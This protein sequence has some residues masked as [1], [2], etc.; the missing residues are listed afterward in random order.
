MFVAFEIFYFLIFVL[1][2]FVLCVCVCVCVLC[3]FCFFN[4]CATFEYISACFSLRSTAMITN[5][6]CFVAKLQNGAHY[7]F[8]VNQQMKERTKD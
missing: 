1:F 4:L 6:G 8:L 3:V 2:C 7:S 5:L